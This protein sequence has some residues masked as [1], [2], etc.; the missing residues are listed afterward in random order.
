MDCKKINNNMENLDS[1]MTKLD[2]K[3]NQITEIK[4]LNNMFNL[5]ELYLCHNQITEIKGLASL[6]NLQVLN[7]N[8]NQITE[9]KGLSTLANLQYLYLN[10]NQI[11]EIK[12]LASLLN[13]QVLNLNNNQ[14]TEIKDL[15]TLAKLQYLYLSYN[16]ITEIK[17][18][19]TLFNLHLLYLD[20][21]QITYTNINY[22][23]L[24]LPPQII[25]CF[26][27]ILNP[28]YNYRNATPRLIK[29]HEICVKAK[30]LLDKIIAAN[31]IK[32]W[33]KNHHLMKPYHPYYIRWMNATIKQFKE[34][35]A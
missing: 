1:I 20:G 34:N 24:Q 22:L 8:S 17:G 18:L 33:Y 2:L 5:R 12:G 29:G 27:N 19:N 21:N 4:N 35:T 16:Q 10:D 14:I 23:T 15:D 11:T 6:L 13:L 7:L 31:T 25:I 9:I 30:L 3:N 28:S 26:A 32:W